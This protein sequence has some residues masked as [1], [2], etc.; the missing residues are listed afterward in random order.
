MQL[1]SGAAFDTIDI[2]LGPVLEQIPHLIDTASI[3]AEIQ[4]SSPMR[5]TCLQS[6]YTKILKIYAV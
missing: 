2:S 1:L 3:Q 5:Q 6:S 4:R